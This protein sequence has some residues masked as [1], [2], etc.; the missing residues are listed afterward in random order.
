MMS[1]SKTATRQSSSSLSS[2]TILIVII[3]IVAWGYSIIFVSTIVSNNAKSSFR[4]E[5][6]ALSMQNEILQKNL[7]EKE[8][9][10]K[11]TSTN[12]KSELISRT[13]ELPAIVVAQ[14]ME[15]GEKA[16]R[17]GVIILGMH[18]SGT[19]LIGGLVNK[20]GLKTGGPLIQAAEDNEKGFFERIDVVLQNDY[21]MQKQGI[22]YSYQTNRFD[23]LQGLKD[24][25]TDTGKLFNEGRRGL[26]FLNDKQNYPWMLKDPRLCITLR[27]WLPLLNFIPAILYTYRHP[28]DVALSMNK[29]ETEHFR[30]N[31][32][33]R[34]WYV[35]NRRAIQQS[36]DLCRVVTSHR[37]V[38][39]Q[40]K[41][42]FDRIYEELRTCG[43]EVPRKLTEQE[44][45]SFIDLKLQ[46]GR[47]TLKDKSCE[48][49]LSQIRPPSTWKTEDDSHIALYREVMRAYCAMESGTAFSEDFKWDLSIIDN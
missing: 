42:E 19:S 8:H 17:P 45:S 49:D 14:R 31:K 21:L 48:E 5:V 1:F 25:L 12:P 34:L 6:S 26:K 16:I 37:K 32:G 9:A 43:V 11:Q 35:Y 15:I 39:Q 29:R 22:G 3:I 38:M 20:M 46:H 7:I 36:N 44:I 30:V 18:R 40:P 24:I 27:M 41:V 28:L 13:E 10:L 33:L 47:T 2:R 4:L 23:H